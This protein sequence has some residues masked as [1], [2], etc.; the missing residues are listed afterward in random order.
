MADAASSA[1]P[2]AAA[3]LG[4]GSE[5]GPEAGAVAVAEGEDD[6]RWVF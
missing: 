1:G 2:A 3:G 6:Q 5:V 4:L